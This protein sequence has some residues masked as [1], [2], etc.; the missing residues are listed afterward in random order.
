MT[1][2]RVNLLIENYGIQYAEATSHDAN[3]QCTSS[4]YID[5]ILDN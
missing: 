2:L 5:A 1:D 4:E 3:F